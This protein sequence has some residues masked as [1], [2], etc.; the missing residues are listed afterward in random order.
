[1]LPCMLYMARDSVDVCG[2]LC[3]VSGRLAFEFCCWV[4]FFFFDMGVVFL[5]C[6]A[7]LSG[8]FINLLAKVSVCCTGKIKYSTLLQKICVC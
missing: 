6:N 1:M 7:L 5:G 8:G 4:V 3:C 2:V